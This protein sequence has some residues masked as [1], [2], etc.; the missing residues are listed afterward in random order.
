MGF[1]RTCIVHSSYSPLALNASSDF[2][3]PMRTSASLSENITQ[4][5]H[6]AGHSSRHVL[7]IPLGS[8]RHKLGLESWDTGAQWC[9][10]AWGATRLRA[11]RATLGQSLCQLQ[12]EE[13]RY[14]EDMGAQLL[15]ARL[16]INLERERCAELT[17]DGGRPVGS[18]AWA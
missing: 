11:G 3:F 15:D 7:D 17:G 10:G 9:R 5:R 6:P 13:R 1:R 12:W 18:P 4:R 16:D 2:M 14:P 8:A